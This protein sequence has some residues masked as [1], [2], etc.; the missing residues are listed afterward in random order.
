MFLRKVQE[1]S[2]TH[3]FDYCSGSGDCGFSTFPKLRVTALLQHQRA[4]LLM[5]PGRVPV[6]GE[7]LSQD[8]EATHRQGS[9]GSCGPREVE[10]TSD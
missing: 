2:V 8:A 6:M 7:E 1:V 10:N 9:E 5:I 3:S 4:M